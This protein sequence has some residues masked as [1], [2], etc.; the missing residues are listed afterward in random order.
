MLQGGEIIII[1]LLALIVLGPKR[2]P[3]VARK[4]GR[5]TVELR[6]AAR[7]ISAGLENEVADLRAAGE[8]LRAVSDELKGQVDEMK[9]PLAEI[10]KDVK[11]ADPRGYEWTGP[12]PL[13]GPT[14]ADAMA[15]LERLNESGAGSEEE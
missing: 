12:K 7:E 13:S 5:W 11:A 4:V 8:D 3:E 6:A 9:Q 1:A 15:D 10:Q 2:L 14:P